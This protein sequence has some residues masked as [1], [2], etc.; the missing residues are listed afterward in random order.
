MDVKALALGLSKSKTAWGGVG[1]WLLTLVLAVL[2]SD[3][4][5][6]LWLGVDSGTPLAV[7]LNVPTLFTVGSALLG[8]V[9]WGRK[10]ARG[11][12]G[13]EPLPPQPQDSALSAARQE[14]EAFSKRIAE[15]SQQMTAKRQALAALESARSEAVDKTPEGGAS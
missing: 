9:L 5:H 15:M 3:Q 8:L 2:A 12:L 4:P 7:P 13:S 14:I 10:T 6:Y 1:Q 11:P